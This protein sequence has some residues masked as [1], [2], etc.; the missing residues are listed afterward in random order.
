MGKH[1]ALG[2]SV[3][4]DAGVTMVGTRTPTGI[5]SA[6]KPGLYDQPSTGLF[7]WYATRNA[8]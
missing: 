1:V 2:V 3:G 4:P 5:S 7:E 6:A 8:G